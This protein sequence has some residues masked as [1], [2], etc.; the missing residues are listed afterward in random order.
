MVFAPLFRGLLAL[1]QLH[2]KQNLRGDASHYGMSQ[3]MNVAV[4]ANHQAIRELLQLPAP[5]TARIRAAELLGEDISV[6]L[7]GQINDIYN[8][9]ANETIDHETIINTL[10][11]KTAY[12]T[13]ISPLELG[14]CL[15]GSDGLNERLRQYA[16][17]AGVAF[18]ISDDILGTF[19]DSFEVGKSAEDD[20]RE[21]KVTL[22]AAHAM[23]HASDEQQKVLRSTLG[24]AKASSKHCD[25]VR[26]IFEDTGAR[27][28]AAK[29][30][31]E[32]ADQA[33]AALGDNA[34]SFLVDLVRFSVSR[35]S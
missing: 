30:A 25:A 21:G 15:A 1:E 9:V 18:Q 14:A 20:I 10:T 24:N 26:E 16:L 34:E 33:I 28:Y 4:F 32:Y 31:R 23:Q 6:T 3:A 8:E 11:W 27:E 22:L 5:D 13:F 2:D 12:Y 7:S 19:G 17:N 35:K 29:T